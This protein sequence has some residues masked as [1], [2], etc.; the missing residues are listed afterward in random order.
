ME[1]YGYV[2]LAAI[3]RLLQKDTQN[4]ECAYTKKEKYIMKKYYSFYKSLNKKVPSEYKLS[5]SNYRSEKPINIDVTYIHKLDYKQKTCAKPS[6]IWTSGL[7]DFGD[8]S[9]T[10]FCYEAKDCTNLHNNI[11][12]DKHSYYIIKMINDPKVILKIDSLKKIKK[13]H[14]KY[15]L[16]IEYTYDSINDFVLNAMH[17][18]DSE[19]YT[20]A[21]FEFVKKHNSYV[22]D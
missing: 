10:D 5:I 11:D 6:G 15:S 17:M 7:F 13:F 19:K 20:S 16:R 14:N 22:I 18:K 8:D 4:T 1:T 9:W 21:L 12:P 3:I 2:E